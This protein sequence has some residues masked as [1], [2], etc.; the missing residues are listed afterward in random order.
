MYTSVIIHLN[1]IFPVGIE[2]IRHGVH[3]FVQ[4]SRQV[5]DEFTE[6]VAVQIFGQKGQNEPVAD[7]TTIGDRCHLLVA[8]EMSFSIDDVEA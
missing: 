6:H 1:L 5:R 2:A 3:A 7:L 8:V 4:I